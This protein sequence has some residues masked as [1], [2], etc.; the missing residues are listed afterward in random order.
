MVRLLSAFGWSWVGVVTT[1]GTYGLSA[2]DSF[3]SQASRRGICVA[4]RSVLPAALGSERLQPAVEEAARVL[5][6][7]SRARVV[8]SFT[9]PGHME[10]LFQELRSQTLSAEGSCDSMRRLWL[11]GDGW[12]STTLPAGANLSLDQVGH[13]VGFRFQSGP[14]TSLQE[15]LQSLA[16]DPEPSNPF[17]RELYAQ[18]S[19]GGTA[20]QAQVA[21]Q[22]LRALNRSARADTTFSIQMAVSAIGQAA[23]A[24]CRGGACG[25]PAVVQP[26]EVL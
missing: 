13:V 1:D 14:T 4:F 21:L 3:L 12:S 8:V 25:V 18:L 23:A 7:N 2:L 26:W 16:A 11:A 9:Q 20:G 17:V 15:F 22:A 10:R 5:R 6:A 24:R 19:A